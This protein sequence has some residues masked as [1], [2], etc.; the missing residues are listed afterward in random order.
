MF[1]KIVVVTRKTRLEELVERFNTVAQ[2]RFYIEHSGGNFS[3]YMREHEAYHSSLAVLRRLLQCGL[4]LQWIDRR[5]CSTFLFTEKDVV[6]TAGQD[7]LVANTAKYVGGQPIIAVNPDSERIDGILLPFTPQMVNRAL[8]QVIEGNAGFREVTMAEALLNDGQKLC[9]FNDLFIGASSHVSARYRIT[10]NGKGEP[11]SSSGVIVSTGAGSTGWLSSIFTMASGVT[12][13]LGGHKGTLFSLPWEDPR[14]IFVVREPFVS[15]HS[16]ADIVAGMLAHG[17]ELV[18][19]S[20]M[21]SGGVI[22]SDGMEADYIGFNS[23]SMAKVH[24]A[25]QRARLVTG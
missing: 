9:A 23:G 14:L 20:L 7:G 4:K 6:V 22:F 5:L 13:F 11:H 1:E 25:P 8:E 18:L 10:W 2:A 21:P 17:E 3:E 24:V 15:R 19:E 16:S 12:G